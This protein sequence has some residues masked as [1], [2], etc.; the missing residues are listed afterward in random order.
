MKSRIS[1]GTAAAAVWLGLIYLYVLGPAV[2]VIIGSFNTATSFPSDFEGFT[3]SWYAQLAEHGEFLDALL[4]SI[5]IG[6][7]AAFVGSVFGIPVSLALARYE[8]R[9]KGLITA[10]IMAPLILPQIVLGL[11]MLQLLTAVQIPATFLGLALIH[12][13]FVMPYV[14]R[15]MLSCLAGVN[16][17]VGEAAAS[18]GANAWQ[19]FMLITLPITRAGVMAGFIFAFIMSFINLPLSLFLTTPASTTLPIRMFAYMESRID[20]FI[21]A[22]G[23][24]TV[25]AVI[26]GSFF[27]EKVL[28]VRLLV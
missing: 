14:I 21:A 2:I 12:S 22:V 19:R 24:L 23:S 13:V 11:A 3:L 1:L 5:E 26:A 8:F 9:F 20:P 6:T 4:V 28:R 27:I 10:F 18:L 7:I 15:A 16:P 25:I 17:S